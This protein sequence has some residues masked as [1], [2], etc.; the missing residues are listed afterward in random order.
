MNVLRIDLMIKYF[1]RSLTRFLKSWLRMRTLWQG[2]LQINQYIYISGLNIILNISIY[3]FL[4]HPFLWKYLPSGRSP[5][6]CFQCSSAASVVRV[7]SASRCWSR[8]RTSTQNSEITVT[9]KSYN[10]F[11]DCQ[12]LKKKIK[13]RLST[14]P[15][16]P[17]I[18]FVSTED[19]ELGRE[20]YN[21]KFFPSLGLFRCKTHQYWVVS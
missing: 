2:S 3:F 20:E 21:I 10:C 16:T 18:L 15:P 12:R 19:K 13:K 14:V 17:G 4:V 7:T 5:F 9:R 1:A 8:W 11:K 6:L